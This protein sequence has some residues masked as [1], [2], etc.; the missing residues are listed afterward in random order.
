MNWESC[1]QFQVYAV[2]RTTDGVNLLYWTTFNDHYYIEVGNSVPGGCWATST[3]TVAWT[4]WTCLF[5]RPI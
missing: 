4:G 5:S 1:Y 3:G 2:A